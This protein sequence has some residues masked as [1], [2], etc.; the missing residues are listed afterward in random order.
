MNSSCDIFSTVITQTEIFD[1]DVLTD[2]LQIDLHRH[3][4]NDNLVEIYPFV[5]NFVVDK[6]KPVFNECFERN[7]KHSLSSYADLKFRAWTIFSRSGRGVVPYHNHSN[8]I[9][10][11]VYYPLVEG[12]TGGDLVLVD[13]RMNA[14]RGYPSTLQD[15]FKPIHVKPKTGS[16]IVFPGYLP[17]YVQEYTGHRLSLAVDLFLKPIGD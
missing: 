11:A 16:C 17:H 14:N 3:D 8:A 9:L 15:H 12:V 13:P 10:S 6:L 7:F 1:T 2:L 4:L 5:N